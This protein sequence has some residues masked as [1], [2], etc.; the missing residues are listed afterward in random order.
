MKS[1]SLLKQQQTSMDQ[2]AKMKILHGGPQLVMI[3]HYTNVPGIS[4]LKENH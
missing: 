1:L 3:S 2:N 4:L